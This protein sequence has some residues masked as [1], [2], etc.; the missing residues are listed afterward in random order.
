M[1]KYYVI[2]FE[3]EFEFHEFK[4]YVDLFEYICRNIDKLENCKCKVIAGEE[5]SGDENE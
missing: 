2:I 3:P 4:R 1:E 5:I